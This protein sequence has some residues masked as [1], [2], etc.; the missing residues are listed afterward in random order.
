[1]PGTEPTMKDN[2]VRAVLG[3]LCLQA[4]AAIFFAGQLASSVDAMHK[5]ITKL[6]SQMEQIISEDFV[7]FRERLTTLENRTPGGGSR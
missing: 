6:S 3:A 4:I 2:W 7:E 1:M 5:S